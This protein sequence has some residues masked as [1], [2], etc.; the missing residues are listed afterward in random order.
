M[1]KKCLGDAD[2]CW[3]R[4]AVIAI[5]NGR[6]KKSFHMDDYSRHFILLEISTYCIPIPD[7]LFSFFYYLKCNGNFS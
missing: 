7:E 2:R 5:E 6:L 3:M 1:K 4:R